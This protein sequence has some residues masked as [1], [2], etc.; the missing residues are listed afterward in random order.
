MKNS[1]DVNVPSRLAGKVESIDYHVGTCM[2]YYI[3]T[4]HTRMCDICRIF[5]GLNYPTP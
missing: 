5:R 1:A 3:R 4:T 2:F